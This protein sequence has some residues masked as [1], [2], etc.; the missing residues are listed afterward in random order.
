MFPSVLEAAMTPQQVPPSDSTLTELRLETEKWKLERD[1]LLLERERSQ[2]SFFQRNW[3]AVISV[4]ISVA[5]VCV[6]FG[7]F[8]SSRSVQR[9]E[10]AI[11]RVETL[12]KFLPD[13]ASSDKRNAALLLLVNSK[14]MD[15]SDVANLA[16]SF[17]ATKVLGDMSSAGNARAG[18]LLRTLN[19]EMAE[20]IKGVYS[21]DASTR[22]AA[23]GALLS[24]WSNDPN[25]VP[26][27]LDSAATNPANE[28]GIY[29]TVV[30][31][32]SLKPEAL[33]PYRGDIRS[34]A[35]GATKIGP[36]TAAEATTLLRKLNAKAPQPPR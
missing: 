6:S 13:L 18:Q 25:L 22:R 23:A 5:A 34:F 17:K 35:A 21:N 29:N 11:K 26:T 28:N 8:Y 7:Q 32:E 12:Q 1:R 15:E 33:S 24:D 10:Y 19:D 16:L 31:L 20:L 14:L 3:Q 27:L 9:Q 2:G 30:L 36:K 4:A